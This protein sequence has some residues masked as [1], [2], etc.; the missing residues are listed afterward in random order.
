MMSLAAVACADDVSLQK[1][2]WDV[3]PSLI[4]P[5][6]PDDHRSIK[7]PSIV[8]HGGRWHLFCTVRGKSRSHQVEYLSFEQFGDLSNARRQML[9]VHDGYYCAPQ[10]FYFEPQQTWYMICQASDESWT[11]AYGAAYSTTKTIE[12]PSSWTPLKSLGHVSAGQKRGLDFWVICD[13]KKAHLFFTTLNGRMWR[14]ET[15]LDAFPLGWSEPKLAIKGDVFEASHTYKVRGQQ[16]YLTFIEAQGQKNRRYFKAYEADTIDGQ[17][18]PI[19]D[20]RDVSFASPLNTVFDG[21][22]W[23]DSFS[24]GEFLRSGVDQTLEVD[25]EH[26]Q[27]IFQG[28]SDVDRVGKPYGEIPWRLGLLSSRTLVSVE[29]DLDVS[30]HSAGVGKLAN[31]FLDEHGVPGLSVAVAR[32][33]KLE[34]ASGYG[35]RDISEKLPVESESLFR[36]A[37]ISKPVTAVAVLQLVEQGHLKLSDSVLDVLNLEH[38]IR[39]VGEKFDDRFRDVTIEQL[40]GHRGGWDRDASF[41]PMF[42]SVQFAEELGVVPPATGNHVI[43]AMLSHPLDFDPGTKYA[44]SNFGYCLLGRAIEQVS[45]LGYEQ[46]VRQHVL[47]PIGID[48]M[49]IGRTLLPGRRP[50]EVRY[51]HEAGRHTSVFADSLGRPVDAPYGAWHLEAMDSHGAWIATASDLA[52][53]AAAFADPHHC[54]LLSAESIKKMFGRPPSGSESAEK[55]SEDAAR[56]PKYYGFGWS[57]RDQPGRMNQWHSGSLPGTATMM[58]RR[59]DGL[60]MVGLVNSR[61]SKTDGSVFGSLDSLLHEIA[62]AWVAESAKKSAAVDR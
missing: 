62:N 55:S 9:D 17:W 50:A 37:S 13:A 49:R 59:H 25:S 8:R 10:V 31:A 32:D 53:F 28:V 15:S 16:R 33:G 27:M 56:K 1:Y 22:S 39:I 44:Y 18:R 57:C 12:D 43:A 29:S 42:R 6:D 2:M 58:I 30:D 4:Q 48:S 21:A 19:A 38:Q 35:L 41:D 5:T 14:E 26:L 34:F 61:E 3:S 51:Y 24:H 40:L 46:Y 11:P 7:D 23:T 60:V 47:S 45:G 52:K 54:P 20:S 36:I